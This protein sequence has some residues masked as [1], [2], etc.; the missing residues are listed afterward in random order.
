MID[1]SLPSSSTNI[2]LIAPGEARPFELGS[3]TADDPSR[4]L[5]VRIGTPVA[6]SSLHDTV[7]MNGSVDEVAVIDASQA[8]PPP[9]TS[10]EVTVHTEMPESL[11]AFGVKSNEV[12]TDWAEQ[13]IPIEAWVDSVSG[14]LHG[15]DLDTAYRF[16]EVFTG[17]HRAANAR[18]I[19]ALRPDVHDATDVATITPL[20][21]AI[22]QPDADGSVMRE[23]P[24]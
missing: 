10:E 16:L 3:E 22:V 2:L 11:T 19:Y 5:V 21:D 6:G 23:S 8:P 15:T 20:F 7:G 17:R 9:G 24:Y 4:F 14:L 18:G 13:D 1:V 12:I